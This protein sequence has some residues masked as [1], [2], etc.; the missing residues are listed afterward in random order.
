M[1]INQLVDILHF[2]D[3]TIDK[4]NITGQYQVL[5]ALCCETNININNDLKQQLHE[6]KKKLCDTLI[7][8]NPKL[9]TDS[10]YRIFIKF[11]KADLLGDEAVLKLHKL[12][13]GNSQNYGALKTDIK[14]IIDSFQQLKLGIQ[15]LILG[16]EPL[17]KPKSGSIGGDIE[18]EE[19]HHL[20]YIQFEEA[21]FIKNI[22]QLEKFC[23][24]WNKILASFAYLTEESV[25]DIRIHDIE[26]CSITFHTGIKTINAITRGAY[27]V[28]KGYKKVL[29]VRRLQLELENLTLTNKEELRNLLEEE[30]LNI[31]DIISSSV[32]TELLNKYGWN[33]RREK[34]EVFNA[35]QIS[36]KQTINFV[37][38]GG[39][40]DSNHAGDLRQINA[41]VIS[42][43]KNI[44]EMEVSKFES[45]A[46]SLE[47][48]VEAENQE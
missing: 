28:L 1:H 7:E 39:K 12:F 6:Q 24:I 5:H 16:L 10:Q 9:W 42:I 37:E 46:N 36:L 41:K 43:L 27:Q 18:L 44:T 38:K 45:E 17:V 35:I 13:D 20:L 8:I 40:I 15:Q 48:F 11:E 22:S 14:N 19:R 4:V 21:L 2:I 31:V 23:R 29:E 47:T 25:E 33:D 34:E 26:S 30:V 3:S 32:T